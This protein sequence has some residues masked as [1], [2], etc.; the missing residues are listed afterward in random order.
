M[1]KNNDNVRGGDSSPVSFP[2]WREVLHSEYADT[3]QR[4][5]LEQDIFAWLK[6]LKA[7]RRRASITSVLDYLQQLEE[8]GHKTERMR[9]SLRWFFMAASQQSGMKEDDTSAPPER[10][11]LIEIEFPDGG[12]PAWEQRMV[13]VMRRR[14]LQWRTEQT[15]RSWAHRFARWLGERSVEEAVDEDIRGFLD[16]LAVQQKVA[17][18]TQKQALNALVFLFREGL[19]RDPGDFS[20]YRPA[21]TGKRIPVVLSV[22]EC[23][24]LFAELSGSHRLMAQLMYGA[25]LRLMELLRLRIQ[26]V[27][28]EQG[29]LMIRSGKGGKDRVGVL[30]ESLRVALLD[31][32]DQLR[33]MFDE[34]RRLNLP[35]V[36]LPA[37]VENKIPT[38]GTQWVWQWFFPS[39]QLALDPRSGLRRRHHLHDAS[40]QNAIRKAA[41]SA[42]L[43][44]R[45]TPHTLRHSFAT[46]LLAGG[47]DIRT[48][49]ELLGHADVSTT[50]IYTH[51]LNRPGLSVR[52][53]LDSF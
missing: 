48:V 49:Q 13:T 4:S 24:A 30:P 19:G 8:N 38:A 10:E 11:Q 53:P 23:Q 32:R 40:F 39:R 41:R 46:H 15:Y 7:S 44:R 16:Y 9:V 2:R 26:D 28:F 17:A 29:I 21:R 43:N 25:G 51:I 27:D 1:Q 34:D 5:F 45:V 36:W 22:R 35:G 6:F 50:M 18:S 3:D 33:E 42:N 52:S 20:G 12:D 47:A 14:H 31:H 37:S